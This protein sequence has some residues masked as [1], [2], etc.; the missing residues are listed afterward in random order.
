MNPKGK[1]NISL[2]VP[3]DSGLTGRDLRKG[4]SQLYS[5]FTSIAK[6]PGIK[7]DLQVLVKDLDI[8]LLKKLEKVIL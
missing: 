8:E 7:S 6:I 2:T 1:K 3:I 5:F 4:I